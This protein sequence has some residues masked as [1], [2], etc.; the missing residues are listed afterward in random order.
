MEQL[1]LQ[2]ESEAALDLDPLL[3]V[4]HWDKACR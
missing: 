4:R 2:L 1:R 3:T